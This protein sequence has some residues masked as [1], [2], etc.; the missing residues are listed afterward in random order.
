MSTTPT[1][2][3]TRDDQ[4]CA[5]GGVKSAGRVLEMLQVF[6]QAEAPQGLTELARRA[7]V[8]KTTAFRIL[9]TL[10]QAGFLER[11]GAT[12]VLSTGLEELGQQAR[13]ARLGSSAEYVYPYLC[14]LF[15]ATRCAAGY[16]VMDGDEALIIERVG[17]L[18]GAGDPRDPYPSL[19]AKAVLARSRGRAASVAT[20]ADQGVSVLSSPFSADGLGAV[21]AAPRFGRHDL[22]D[23]AISVKITEE[24]LGALVLTTRDCEQIATIVRLLRGAAQHIHDARQVA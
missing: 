7:G 20:L 8:P 24:T 18:P 5:S 11:R 6:R 10:E 1:P 21:V 14:E 9:A 15:A 16:A 23:V 2:L 13:R 12:Y 19:A 17:V 22:I 3:K 4:T